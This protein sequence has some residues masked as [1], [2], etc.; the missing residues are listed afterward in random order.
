MKRKRNK[1]S[2]GERERDSPHCDVKLI[3]TTLSHAQ[4]LHAIL[5]ITQSSLPF[6][7]LYFQYKIFQV[8]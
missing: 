3:R 8:N 7:G 4:Y 5:I 6:A 1:E 2:E